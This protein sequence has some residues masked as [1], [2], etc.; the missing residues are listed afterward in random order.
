MRIRTPAYHAL[1]RT[2]PSRPGCNRAPSRAGS[3]SYS[4][5]AQDV[6][7]RLFLLMFAKHFGFFLG[8]IG[9][10]SRA[11]V[12]TSTSGVLLLVSRY[13]PQDFCS[14]HLRANMHNQAM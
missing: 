14:T 3:L 4:C 12:I 2:R 6:W 9:G 13:S 7:L 5:W 11:S 8:C 10:S 1:A